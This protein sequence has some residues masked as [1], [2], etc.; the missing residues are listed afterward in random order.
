MLS[1]DKNVIDRRTFP[2]YGIPLKVRYGIGEQLTDG[3]AVDIS[4]G[5]I[6]FT[7]QKTQAVG[8]QIQI[9]FQF[10]PPVNK[11]FSMHAVIRRVVEKRMGAKF[12]SIGPVEHS[13]ILQ[14]IY[15]YLALQ[16]RG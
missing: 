3:D 9:N 8:E 1:P 6:G 16:R 13:E 11:L 2:R 4:Q 10:A 14:A 12:L 15:Q 7:G 5:G